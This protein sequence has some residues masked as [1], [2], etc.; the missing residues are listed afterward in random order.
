M[1]DSLW[2]VLGDFNFIRAPDNRNRPRGHIN[3]MF[4]FN[5]IIGHLGLDELP[6]K[7][8]SYIWSNMQ[9]S[10]LLEQLDQFFITPNWTSVFPNTLVLP[11]A[12]PSSDHVPCVVSVDTNIP[13]THIFRFE[14]YWI[15]LPGF[16]DC[17]RRSWSN[18]SS[19][20]SAAKLAQKLKGLRYDLKQ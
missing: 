6:L 8:R 17:V 5:E 4:I 18:P 13:K 2:M 12:R 7:G 15:D 20:G 16:M 10:P 9:D 19:K 1:P 3:D 14:N 11:L